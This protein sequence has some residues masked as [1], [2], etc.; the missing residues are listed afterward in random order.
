MRC[1]SLASSFNILC[2]LLHVGTLPSALARGAKQ[3]WRSTV[4]SGAM[5]DD[6]GAARFETRLTPLVT[7]PLPV[8]G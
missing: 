3:T 7:L 2:N 5:L 1:T 4:S 8:A 6:D